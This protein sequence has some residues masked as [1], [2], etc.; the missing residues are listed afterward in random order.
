MH[1]RVSRKE[2]LVSCLM[3]VSSPALVAQAW[4]DPA[5]AASNPLLQPGNLP[6]DR[7]TVRPHP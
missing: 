4:A 1:A 6:Y 3:A 2:L 5:P 7:A